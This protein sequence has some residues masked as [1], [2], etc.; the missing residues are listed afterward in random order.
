MNL[1]ASKKLEQTNA[2]INFPSLDDT[3]IGVILGIVFLAVA[4]AY[5]IYHIQIYFFVYISVIVALAI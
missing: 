5:I 2:V 3:S 1:F 4:L